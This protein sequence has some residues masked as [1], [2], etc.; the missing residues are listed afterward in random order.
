[1]STTYELHELVDALR[2]AGLHRGDIV[3][4]FSNLALFGRPNWA[5]N[6]Q[7]MCEGF[8]AAFLEVIGPEGTLVVPTFTYSFCKRET[9]DPDMSASSCGLL[10]EWVRTRPEA[11]R[12]ED[13]NFSV[14]AIGPKSY[15]LTCNAPTESFGPF[16][17]WE[18]LVKADGFICNFNVFEAGS[19]LFHYVE[20]KLS[21]PYRFDKIFP[22]VIRRKGV[23]QK[24]AAIYFCQDLSN[25]M[26]A[27][28]NDAFSALAFDCGLARKV[29][30]GQGYV[31]G[32][33][34]ADV[35]ALVEQSLPSRPWL[36]TKADGS[37]QEPVLLEEST[38]SAAVDLPVPATMWQMVESL[39][40]L[41]RDI[42]SDGYDLAL[43]TL[44]AQVPM[45]IHKYPTGTHA[46]TWI[47][48]E[49]WT[50]HE[51]YLETLNGRRLF[52]YADNPLHVVSYS[53]PFDGEVQRSELLSHLHVHPKLPEAIPFQFKYYE[54]EW[55]LCC[56]QSMRESL[57]DERYRVVINSEFSYGSLK[58]GEVIVP[59][60]SKES[61]VL[62]AHLCHPGQVN[63]DLSGVLVGI[64]VMRELLK[65]PQP[66]YTYRF[67]ILPETI[68]S[69]AWLSH[70]ENLIPHLRGGLFL[71]MLGLPNPHALQMSFD[72][73]TAIDKC[74]V[75]TLKRHDP[76]GWT[77][78]F[79]EVLGNDERQF[80]SP[81]VRVPMLSLLRVLKPDNPDYP[82]LEY[83]SSEDNP[84]RCSLDQ[85][86]DSRDLVIK[87][88][89][90]LE[91]DRIPFPLFKGEPFCSRF[92]LQIDPYKNPEGNKAFMDIVYLI[93]GNR[94][95]AQ[96][97][98]ACQVDRQAVEGVL[99][100]MEK[101]GLIHFA[102]P[103]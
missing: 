38:E 19:T 83:H 47:V 54:R 16:S 55:G 13:P 22:G 36:L 95:V 76:N 77:A 57:T 87:M 20:R 66:H 50:C 61:F 11:V 44:A 72:G 26:T 64:E 80:N 92:G 79:R 101:H 15:E 59:G 60:R 88:I 28:S 67:L 53:L 21:V 74:L 10:A 69:I 1:M 71:E 35:L 42:V 98:D 31:A 34:A 2:K 29:P 62:C 52:S 103:A 82:Y 30:L 97:A 99:G 17:F 84:A 93:D 4:A 43:S 81:G 78:K 41:P 32:I 46:W 7:E 90:D 6:A 45:M 27:A 3:L 100:D 65:R 68:G 96:I 58:V 51:A 63:D 39:W 89:D 18:R 24:T 37:T 40:K 9:F 49:K 25:A 8:V 94:S 56:S 12:S 70:N 75:S 85:L 5:Q 102:K 73:N 14:A 48:P 33:R 86:A 23:E 91:I